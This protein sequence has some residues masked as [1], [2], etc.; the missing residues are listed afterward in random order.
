MLVHALIY[1]YRLCIRQ[2]QGCDEC[3]RG[4]VSAGGEW[5]VLDEDW[6]VH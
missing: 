1:L 6:T 3:C 5:G 4:V 2:L